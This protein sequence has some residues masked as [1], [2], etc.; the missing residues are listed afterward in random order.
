[1]SRSSIQEVLSGRLGTDLGSQ[2]VGL[3]L[4]LNC[5]LN[6]SAGYVGRHR[7]IF[8]DA[9]PGLPCF[10]HGGQHALLHGPQLGAAI[11]GDRCGFT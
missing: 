2:L 11:A 6:G 8:V 9:E 3:G 10:V 4:E 1:M 5:L 7:K